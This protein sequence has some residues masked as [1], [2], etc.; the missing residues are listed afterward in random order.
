[1]GLQ[2]FGEKRMT[3]YKKLI[4]TI[5]VTGGAFAINYLINFFL[6]RFI[7]QNIGT[8]AYGFVGVAKNFA[9]YAMIVTIALN[10]YSSR[11]IA[12][13][14][15]EGNYKKA[16]I[17][18][19][20]VLIAD[21][22]LGVAIFL[23]AFVLSI[24]IDAFFNLNSQLVA[25]VRILFILIFSNLLINTSGTAL[26]AAA[27]IKNKLDIIGIVRGVSYCL[28]ALILIVCYTF[29]GVAVYFVG[30]GMISATILLFLANLLITRKYTSELVFAP[31]LFSW[32]A[33]KELVVEGVW[34]SLN[35]LG[36]S[37]NNGLD[38][39]FANIMLSPMSMGQI[40]I[41]KSVFAIFSGVYQLVAQPFQPMFLKD[42][43]ANNKVELIKNLKLSMKISGLIS[44][45]IFAG[46]FS[47]GMCYFKLW[48][49]D[50][51]TVLMYNL[52]LLA[53]I[54]CI[55]EGPIYPLYYIYTL[56]IKN[57]IPCLIT[58]GGG[59]LNV[60]GMY[61]LI[62]YTT[63]GIYSIQIT[64]AVIMLCIS[65]ISNPIYM[66]HCLGEKWTVFYPALGKNV[67]SCGVMMAIMHLISSLT[68]PSTWG[69]L[70]FT[71]IICVVLGSAL[72]LFIVFSKNEKRKLIG[73]VRFKR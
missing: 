62:K 16:N 64:T 52:T 13:E 4:F 38:L 2:L 32:N 37:L 19:N 39:I 71:A 44:N 21:F 72:H 54:T 27:Y 9:S 51:N 34:N 36:N 57:K 14:Y 20:S 46:F 22:L 59:I 67:L 5:I 41:I 28:E 42:Y 40:S 15:H 69:Q 24:R 68:K 35:S 31:K 7:T 60:L 30:I 61:F 45:L 18:F 48:V 73:L 12:V 58:I 55:L 17:Y 26:Q 3:K 29:F 53:T 1:M 47:L 70:I 23:V 11:Y 8:D 65:G 49:P 66:A 25:D 33:V 10:S 56:T 6:T 63:L 43:A 50:Q